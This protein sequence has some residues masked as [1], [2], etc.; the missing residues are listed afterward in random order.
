M[1]KRFLVLY[2]VIYLSWPISSLYARTLPAQMQQAVISRHIKVPAP[3][4]NALPGTASGDFVRA[5]AASLTQQDNTLVIDQE[6]AKVLLEWATFDIGSG[7]T[8]KFNQNPEDVAVNVIQDARPSRIFGKLV[9]DGQIYLLNQN[10]VIFGEGS[11]VNVRGM[12]AAAAKLNGY[13][14]LAS[15][16]EDQKL[17]FLQN[18]LLDVIG[19][20]K[21]L[22]VVDDEAIRELGEE[23][24]PR[25]IVEKGA[26]I[27]SN[28]AP[29][30][31]AGPEV[32]NYG[33]ILASNSQVVLAGGRK[34]FYLA[35]SDN[36][37][38]LRGYLVEV[39]SG[40]GSERGKVTNAGSIV[41]TL[42][43][44]TLVGSEI[45]QAGEI[46]ATSAVDVNGSI[47]I[48]ARDQAKEVGDFQTLAR[49][50]AYWSAANFDVA[51]ESTNLKPDGVTSS[52]GLVPD[53]PAD[54]QTNQRPS[55][56]KA[57]IGR[58]GGSVTF[59]PG[60][61]TQVAVQDLDHGKLTPLLVDHGVDP[62]AFYKQS[63]AQ[64]I[65][66]IK[67]LESD[68]ERQF[69][70][71]DHVKYATN[72]SLQRD[73]RL[74]VAGK[75]IDLQENS[76]LRAK[77]AKIT[78]VS[79]TGAWV[80]EGAAISLVAK[81]DPLPG[82]DVREANSEAS[83]TIGKNALIDASGTTNTVLEA[84]RNVVSMFVTSSEVK[85]NA[86]QKGGEL[87]RK[88]VA[89]DIRKGTQLF[90]WRSALDTV[91]KTASERSA[92]GGRVVVSST[93][94]VNLDQGA[95]VDVSGGKV[96]YQEGI[97]ETSKVIANGRLMDISEA[98]ANA[99]IDDVID[100]QR[101]SVMDSKWGERDSHHAGTV[102][103]SSLNYYP[104]YEEGH[105]GG[106][107][108][109]VANRQSI[110]DGINL[111]AAPYIGLYQR[112]DLGATG[113]SV[114][115]DVA[116]LSGTQNIYIQDGMALIEDDMEA[117]YLSADIIES[118]G[119]D[120][121]RISGTQSIVLE[122]GVQLA[123]G[124]NQGLELGAGY[125]QMLGDVRSLG[126]DVVLDA[127]DWVDV[128]G[129][130]DVSGNWV[131]RRLDQVES[132]SLVSVLDAG[133][134]DFAAGKS[135]VIEDEARLRANAGARLSADGK[136]QIGH[137][138]EVALRLTDDGRPGASNAPDRP[139]LDMR[140]RV[141]ALD[142]RQGG[143]FSLV[144]SDIRIGGD[145]PTRL[146]DSGGANPDTVTIAN[147]WFD[148]LR[149]GNVTLS[150]REGDITLGSDAD[151]RMHQHAYRESNGT[152]GTIS[153]DSI[154][155]ALAHYEVPTYEALAGSLTLQAGK[156]NSVST[157]GSVVVE[158][159]ATIHGLYGSTLNLHADEAILFDGTFRSKGGVFNAVLDQF[160]T[161]DV[162][163]I[164]NSIY[165]GENAVI[166]LAADMI[167]R[168]GVNPAP[169]RDLIAAGQVN[170]ESNLGYVLVDE[171]ATISLQGGV[172]SGVEDI[173]GVTRDV[174]RAAAA[175]TFKL[176]ADG[177]FVMAAEVDFGAAGQ[178]Y[179]GGVL[180][181]DL[182]SGRGYS[183]GERPQ[184]HSIVLGADR[185]DDQSSAF[186]LLNDLSLNAVRN[187]D[188]SFGE[189]SN[190]TKNL[191]LIATDNLEQNHVRSARLNTDRYVANNNVSLSAQSNI[192]L[193]SDVDVSTS[194]SLILDSVALDLADHQLSL[195][196]A[197]VQIGDSDNRSLLTDPALMPQGLPGN[198]VGR[199]NINGGLVDLFGDLILSGDGQAQLMA[200][201]GLRL[202]SVLLNSNAFD[203]LDGL[204]NESLLRV[205]G[206]LDIA[207]PVIWTESYAN[208][209]LYSDGVIN[210]K[211][212]GNNTDSILSVGSTLKLAGDAI[213]VD[214]RVAASFGEIVLDATGTPGNETAAHQRYGL[215]S[216]DLVLGENAVLSVASTENVPMGRI[217]ADG[218]E[219]ELLFN[220]QN[221][222]EINTIDTNPVNKIV[223]L[224]GNR[225]LADAGS[226]LDVSAGGSVYGREFEAGLEGS[227]DILADAHYTE[228]F[229]IVPTMRSGYAAYDPLE[230]RGSGLNEEWG[231]Q[232]QVSGSRQI[233]DGLYTVL[234]ANYALLPG[235]YL[236]RPDGDQLVRRGYAADNLNGIEVVSGRVVHDG[237]RGES[238]WTG[239]TL[240]ADTELSKYG[241]YNLTSVDDY[242]ADSD[243]APG[244]L[245][246]AN[247]G[248]GIDV[249]QQLD[250]DA[251]VRGSSRSKVGT[252]VDITSP[253]DILV[254]DNPNRSLEDT[255]Q[256][257]AS[258]F[259]QIGAGSI[260]LGGNR[261]WQDGG[262][263][264]DDERNLTSDIMVDDSISGD[265]I[266]LVSADTINLGSAVEISATGTA[267]YRGNAWDISEAG[268]ALLTS[269]SSDSQFLLDDL[270]NMTGVLNLAS[271]SRIQGSG[272]VAIAHRGSNDSDEELGQERG[273]GLLAGVVDAL[274]GRLQVFA[275]ELTLGDASTAD[276][277]LDTAILTTTSNLEL[278]SGDVMR[279]ANDL[280]LD[281]NTLQL[282]ANSV[283]V[284]ENSR[285]E[286]RA[287][288]QATIQ[289]GAGSITNG[290]IAAGSSLLV[291]ADT[292]NIQGSDGEQAA[293]ISLLAEQVELG[294]GNLVN[295]TGRLSLRAGSG[296]GGL[297]VDS[298]LLGSRQ[299][300]A[301]IE[302][303]T[304]GDLVLRN[305]DG[306]A[307]IPAELA[308]LAPGHSIRLFGDAV[309]L[310]TAIAN[311]S[312]ITTLVA[313]SGQL[314]LGG[315]A[316]IDASAYRQTFLDETI[317]GPAGI[318]SLRAAQ[319]ITIEEMSA[320][321]YGDEGQSAN[322]G[323]LEIIAGDKL[324]LASVQNL[325]LGNGGVDL[326]IQAQRFAQAQ[327][328]SNGLSELDAI[329]GLNAAGAN[330]DLEL[331]LTGVG[332]NLNLLEGQHDLAAE[333]FYLAAARGSLTVASDLAAA[334]A[335]HQSGLFGQQG[336]SL[337]NTASITVSQSEAGGAPLLLH[338]GNGALVVSAGARLNL[339]SGLE[340]MLPASAAGVGDVV[341]S[342]ND[343]IGAA[344]I[345]V[346]GVS[347]FA[348]DNVPTLSQE[349]Q[350]SLAALD[351]LSPTDF[352]SVQ[353]GVDPVA[354]RLRPQL[355]IV[356][357]AD[358]VIGEPGQ[359]L[360]LMS[361]RTATGDPGRVSF[362]ARE[363]ITVQGGISDGVRG[364]LS[365]LSPAGITFDYTDDLNQSA[366]A[367]PVLAADESSSLQ[368]TAGVAEG[369]A[370]NRSLRLGS[371]DILLRNNSYVRTGT[372][373]IDVQASGDLL[374]E[375]TSYIATLGRNFKLD[376]AGLPAWGDLDYLS[377]ITPGS[378]PSLWLLYGKFGG[379]GVQGGDIRLAVGGDL[380][381]NSAGI[382]SAD[383]MIRYNTEDD[384]SVLGIDYSN[385]TSWYAAIGDLRGGVNAVGGGSIAAQVGG[386]VYAAGF[387]A[388]SQGVSQ[389]LELAGGDIDLSARADVNNGY[390]HV[391]NGRLKLLVRG[392][393]A[394]SL[395]I[396]SEADAEITT[397]G[398][399]DFGGMI[400]TFMLPGDLRQSAQPFVNPSLIDQLSSYYF[401]GYDS[402]SLQLT[403]VAGDLNLLADMESNSGLK[404][405][406]PRFSSAYE[407]LLPAYYVL[408]SRV[409]VAALAGSVNI[410]ERNIPLA[411]GSLTLS[412]NV[413]TL[414]PSTSSRIKLYAANGIK[415]RATAANVNES[416]EIYLP[417]FLP[418]D[419]PSMEN[420]VNSLRSRG[421][422]AGILLPY[423]MN[424]D[425]LQFNHRSS[426][427][428]R[429]ESIASRIVSLSGGIGSED[430]AIMF[431]LPHRVE[432]YSGADMTNAS[433]VLQHNNDNDL[434][435][436]VAAGDIRF[437][438]DSRGNNLTTTGGTQVIQVAG[439]G[440]LLMQAGGNV[441]L[442]ASR[443]ILS[444][445]NDE[446]RNLSA[447]GAS[448]H[449]YAGL[450]NTLYSDSFNL[451]G[452]RNLVG[453]G[454]T[455]NNEIAL[456]RSQ[457]GASQRQQASFIDLA[458]SLLNS[459][460]PDS[461]NTDYDLYLILAEVLSSATGDRYESAQ[462]DLNLSAMRRDFAELEVSLQQ[463]LAVN[464]VKQ[465]VMK[466]P[467]RLVVGA[468]DLF[469]LPAIGDS[470]LQSG[471]ARSNLFRSY[472]ESAGSFIA[473]DY[474]QGANRTQ[475][476]LALADNRTLEQVAQLPAWQQLQLAA[477]A[478]NQLD[479][480][481]QLLVA[482]SVMLHHN[483]A[484]AEEGAAAGSA[485]FN[486]ERGYVA[487]RQFF[488]SDYD[489]ALRGMDLKSAMIDI[490]SKSPGTLQNMLSAHE[491]FRR[492]VIDRDAL[493]RRLLQLS[494]LDFSAMDSQ[495][496]V[497]I[498]QGTQQLEDFN[499]GGPSTTD[500][501][502]LGAL[503]AS[504]QQDAGVDFAFPAGVAGG[505]N[506]DMRF[507]T[508]QTRS[509]GDIGLFT[510]AGSTDVGV[511]QSLVDALG[512]DKSNGELG[513]FSLAKGNISA[514]VADAFNVNES[515]VIPAA[516]GDINLWSVFGDI[517]AGRGAKTAVAA[518]AT[519]FT[520]H[521]ETAAVTFIVP[522]TVA[523][524]GIQTRSSR[525]ASSA[526]PSN[527]E[528]Y[529]S[530]A[531]GVGS[532][533]LAT[534]LGIVDAGEAG[535]QSAGDLF[536]GAAKV[537]GADNISVGGIS[538]G[539]PT[540]T[541]IS[542]DVGGL[543]SAV[544]AATNSI[545]ESAEKAAAEQ[546][547]QNAA[548]VTIELL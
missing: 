201:Q 27:H 249:I 474:L 191:G 332:S 433:F 363:G 193:A 106:S 136:L 403:S 286:L 28:D 463:R 466:Q 518:P 66:Q 67:K 1:L 490:R 242:F 492:G 252:F 217:K 256:L 359:A 132:S 419:L 387:A 20:G 521:P 458:E 62:V 333:S 352:I 432:A 125:I 344:G 464:F 374:Q 436:I 522:P 280:T 248:V 451:E 283:A 138:G 348:S 18:S 306:Q 435:T 121:F 335:Q 189:L 455:N 105:D 142:N 294:G 546:A 119:A 231:T 226:V 408:P 450:R 133:T 141:E 215:A 30:V 259:D 199:L 134:I 441:E 486:F 265:E 240:E 398:Q 25:I 487:Q 182:S 71:S 109:I 147:Q 495:M 208:A 274:G 342:N 222:T 68:A 64:Q 269:N 530:I 178:G 263:A 307:A 175:G 424:S 113:G 74:H 166:D 115:I 87:L 389:S 534:P 92:Q 479:A 473:L 26:A 122:P 527:T 293:G 253:G 356:S 483:A 41:A 100:L 89:V 381:G 393:L 111:R 52:A 225:V 404:R 340:V 341:I 13:D 42:G 117:L 538:T 123:L 302:L 482:E 61:V 476:F 412:T 173:Q 228:L 334:N 391:D 485:V 246:G 291:A 417:D 227:V 526:K 221:P 213:A 285:V 426:R 440:D 258:L 289:A 448:L 70:L 200:Q 172:F 204:F 439:P 209:T 104:T 469:T 24:L 317:T 379:F 140:G 413:L 411:T 366:A 543:G 452:Y 336:L 405:H 254:G 165:L 444:I 59:A 345:D 310:D 271:G 385:I 327:T 264:I 16:S 247:G 368:L 507:S 127:A 238:L 14:D 523:G 17:T 110:A 438:L 206:S 39:N 329:T 4:A 53:P 277:N 202:R 205:N 40:S 260:L 364:L 237:G 77:G 11:Q 456:F 84:E 223:S 229:A 384:V 489:L 431:R 378:D 273:Q 82:N 410:D 29:V 512:F 429:D 21:A 542:A 511:S 447:N 95:T 150:A 351:G 276:A 305:S 179:R 321:D 427:I 180:N 44:V 46:K 129:T 148:Q 357:D 430:E 45:I 160:E 177:G 416:L 505:G 497:D 153:G 313:D 311:R 382:T 290:S 94:S 159:G 355:D 319:D 15:I 270:A 392:A 168:P 499:L 494:R 126:G 500:L 164:G 488:G 169:S 131:N 375:G 532:I 503:L 38:D 529:F 12:I 63:E 183:G 325:K 86:V 8:V 506:I 298:P 261:T 462:L 195:N 370:M 97:A 50:S 388:P 6:T 234:P 459:A 347:T 394:D 418:Q 48:M 257:S 395:F 162:P 187:A 496:V 354:L 425:N 339:E 232:F 422:V 143:Q 102:L 470:G 544:D 493:D 453:D 421:Q 57:F 535:I 315:E 155:G 386:T 449:V 481:K 198:G 434:S 365:N 287:N 372:G 428:E 91:Q 437:T 516:G 255:L 120:S 58:E 367:V 281:L 471:A 517:D 139:A 101:S 475:D 299:A 218:V 442:G 88:T 107:I 401:K 420:P 5:G 460:A 312:G 414:F 331:I 292:L 323:V 7:S 171:S 296:Q 80:N 268:A 146:L 288:E 480:G 43:N 362:R 65:A 318:I 337:G 502:S 508:I 468:G 514:V 509:G 402:S 224:K 19:D 163:S 34:D 541:S 275:N 510:P 282:A 144:A 491:D 85:D 244:R 161:T 373:N 338:S 230:F 445:A 524:S 54:Q 170:L 520:V 396:G 35:V 79:G 383:Y 236:V 96:T 477:T 380:Q 99:T 78:E 210:L 49:N 407:Q 540:A 390:Y 303:A 525:V 376:S 478:F 56:G 60:S 461:D 297:V 174:N 156:T 531:E 37:Y 415:A 241:T 308:A 295:L 316:Y 504:W 108:D 185:G 360:D 22:L 75:S 399:L 158:Q 93:G 343:V 194:E 23:N 116:G 51:R 216:G 304:E 330:G 465:V 90:D 324:D 128:A 2:L 262:W 103:M 314:T 539:V 33:D 501:Q 81:E 358:L 548:F 157:K 278:R 533:A 537:S 190:L 239:F 112:D 137:A 454:I 167:S 9:A 397:I 124:R 47:H 272:T 443:G 145:D 309:E 513:V 320:F 212:T 400:N 184:V 243:L 72:Q 377:G 301:R 135:L 484:A 346:F 188:G 472:L 528:R 409:G 545:Q 176:K 233:G 519:T 322:D 446:N 350:S 186:S 55:T 211:R 130:I 36:D 220:Y 203:T 214:T 361:Y 457:L 515:R 69:R 279:F 353:A 423:G 31:L 152:A 32:E 3:A 245:P 498:I 76:V 328:D 547:R 284:A 73:S 219:W 114:H 10:G 326:R 83:I 267:S 349:L 266:L 369:S 149:V 151:I 98:P 300:G 406:F 181:F 536:L 371:A 196:S 250:F 467:D 235:A 207:T 154:A 118:S 251:M 192:R 197:Y